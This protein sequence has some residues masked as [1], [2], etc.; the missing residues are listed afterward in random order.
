MERSSVWGERTWQEEI[1]V[2]R[3]TIKP[4]ALPLCFSG[5]IRITCFKKTKLGPYAASRKELTSETAI[6]RTPMSQQGGE[7]IP[8]ETWASE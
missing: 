5:P 2:C 3:R 4:V 8:I 7:W 6:A 1:R